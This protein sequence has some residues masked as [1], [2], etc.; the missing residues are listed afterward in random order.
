MKHPIRFKDSQRLG[1]R[2]VD[3]EPPPFA[4]VPHP[5][6]IKSVRPHTVDAGEWRIEFLATI[7]L[8]A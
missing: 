7:M 4:R 5:V 2:D 8:H 3:M 1:K 6:D